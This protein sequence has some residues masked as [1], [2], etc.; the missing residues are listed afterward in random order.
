MGLGVAF[1]NLPP[2]LPSLKEFYHTDNARIAFLVSSLVLAHGFVQ[3]PAGM[4]TDSIGVKK[5]LLMSLALLFFS[6]LACM[7]NLDYGFVLTMRLFSGV[8]TGFAFASGIK[9]ASVFTSDRHR[10]M[11]QGFFGGSFSIGGVMPFFVMPSLMLIDM[12]L[13]FLVTALFYVIPFA[14]L[15]IWGKEVKTKSAVKLAHFKPVFQDKAIW[16]LGLLHAVFFGGVVTLGTWFSAFAVHAD[17][18]LSLKLAGIWGALIMF[19]SGLARFIGGGLLMKFLPVKIILYSFSL[20]LLSYILLVLTDNFMILIILYCLAAFMSSVT[21]GPI[22]YLSSVISK[23]ELAA[24][25]FGIVNF[26]ANLGSLVWPV[27]FGYFI[28]VTGNYS[29][30][31]LFMGALVCSGII[32]TFWLKRLHVS[33]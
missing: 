25:G 33:T 29:V 18:G 30:S 9:Y 12:R 28:D 24:T 7:F 6:N 8:G 31:F 2:V 20:L 16:V 5:T 3:I 15:L 21:F 27:I 23:M 17:P 19:I 11:M 32:M 22:F 13:I 14:M 1:V 26:I 4:I 10:G